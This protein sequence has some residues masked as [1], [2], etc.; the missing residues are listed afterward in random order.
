MVVYRKRSRLNVQVEKPTNFVDDSL[1]KEVKGVQAASIADGNKLPHTFFD[2]SLPR[3]FD[4]STV[5]PAAELIAQIVSRN[6]TPLLDKN[7]A[8]K[9]VKTEIG[10]VIPV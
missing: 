2:R 9:P 8:E 3:Y 4:D 6:L 7:H 10:L 1:S 5:E